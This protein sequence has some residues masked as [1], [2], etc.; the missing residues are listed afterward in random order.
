MSK[1]I[2]GKDG[3]TS[4]IRALAQK[5]ADG[6]GVPRI[7]HVYSGGF[8]TMCE[9]SPSVT[10]NDLTDVLRLLFKPSR[11]YNQYAYRFGAGHE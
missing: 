11:P 8:E 4:P 5:M 9:A 7:V 10:R 2:F 6:D 3:L 1:G